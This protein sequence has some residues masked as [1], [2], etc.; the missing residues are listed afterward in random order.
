M[1]EQERQQY[2]S[3]L[4]AQRGQGPISL[5][6]EEHLATSDTGVAMLRRLLTEQIKLVQQG[7]DP[8]GVAYTAEGARIK[9][10]SGNFF[11]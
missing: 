9:T 10:L 2:P 4:E 11:L 8:L 7:G 6:S 1:S 5:H 3:D